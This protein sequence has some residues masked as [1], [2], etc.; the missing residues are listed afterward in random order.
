MHL[1]LLTYPKYVKQK[2]VQ[3]KREEGKFIII[4]GDFNT[5]LSVIK[6]PRKKINKDI[7]VLSNTINQLDLINIRKEPHLT[8]A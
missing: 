6:Q 1:H 4:L 8:I 5:H 3:L 2:W 7:E